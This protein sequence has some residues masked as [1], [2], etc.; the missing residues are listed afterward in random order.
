LASFSIVINIGL[1][2]LR[3]AALQGGS[4]NSSFTMPAAAM[5]TLVSP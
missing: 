4:R 5:K 1:P 2:L 3:R